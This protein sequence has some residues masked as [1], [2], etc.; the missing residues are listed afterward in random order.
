MSLLSNQLLKS[1][2]S[3]RPSF[4]LR[5]TDGIRSSLGYTSEQLYLSFTRRCHAVMFSHRNNCIQ[6]TNAPADRL[7]VEGQGSKKDGVS[8][9]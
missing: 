5:T 3:L 2:V 1:E 9:A 7:L 6:C 4:D 8:I